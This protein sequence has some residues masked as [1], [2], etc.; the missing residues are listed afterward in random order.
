MAI[1]IG[2]VIVSLPAGTVIGVNA[3]EPGVVIKL[4][5]IGAPLTAW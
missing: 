5:G 4:A 2:A 1:T 3:K